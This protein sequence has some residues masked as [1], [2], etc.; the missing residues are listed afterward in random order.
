MQSSGWLGWD[1]RTERPTFTEYSKEVTR[2]WSD[3]AHALA[4]AVNACDVLPDVPSDDGDE[5]LRAWS[6][7]IRLARELGISLLA[8]DAALRAFAR[9]QGVSAF[10]SLHLLEALIQDETLPADALEQSYRRLMALPVAELPV[11]DRLLTIARSEQWNPDAYAAFLFTR[12]STWQPL[13]DGWRT[14][15]ALIRALPEKD[16]E[17]AAGWCLT[18]LR[19]LCLIATA[20]TVP[21]VAG[22]LV[23]WTLFE[24]ADGS[25][26]PLLLDEAEHT[27]RLVAPEADLLQEVVQRLVTTVR[28]TTPADQ[29]GPIVL[30][31]LA[32]LDGETHV[33]ALKIFF[34]MP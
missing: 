15:S 26:L 7:P 34:T 6:A 24:L 22:T 27:V 19:G 2:S 12:P 21:A 1:P 11:R 33:K 4:A 3:Q 29:V 31:L 20:P 16:P 32:G 25:A 13:A 23:A 30:R 8:D 17:R 9:S 14:Y 18:A 28:R 10:G 5:D